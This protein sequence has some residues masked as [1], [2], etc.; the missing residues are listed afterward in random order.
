MLLNYNADITENSKWLAT[1]PNDTSKKLPFYMNEIG[2]FICNKDYY[3]EREGQKNYFLMYTISGSGYL[4]YRKNE[5]FLTPGT[6]TLIYCNDYQFYKTYS[7]EQWN[8]R[9]IHFNGSSAKTYMELL[10]GKNLSVV[11]IDNSLDFEKI[12][13]KLMNDVGV[14]DIIA[15]INVS[16]YITELLSKCV[17]SKLSPHNNKAHFQH[18]KEI[19]L[20]I[21]YITTNYDKKI[22]LDDLCDIIHVSKFHFLKLFKTYTGFTPYEYLINHRINKAKQLLKN[23]DSAVRE[24]CINV[25]FNDESSFIKQFKMATG[26]TPLNYRRFF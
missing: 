10:N 9:W 1:T 4:K 17:A 15:N 26:Y 7:E 24:V 21:N 19:E 5:Y 25:G 11:T 12:H 6:A 14:N 20:V 8:Y 22:S 3:T 18:K 2:H 16:M 13:E 23:T